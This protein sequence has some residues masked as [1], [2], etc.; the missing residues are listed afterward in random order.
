MGGWCRFVLGLSGLPDEFLNRF[1]AR[2]PEA[3]R[4]HIDA[5]AMEQGLGTLRT[6][7]GEELEIAGDEARALALIG[8]I[9]RQ[10]QEVAETVCIT[11]ERTAEE[12]R[13]GQSFPAELV[14]NGHRI[15]E[16]LA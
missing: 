13:N 11:I 10:D 6:A 12:M 14:R 8:L 7:G 15:P 5:D 3:F 2:L 16:L 1:E 9:K 4:A